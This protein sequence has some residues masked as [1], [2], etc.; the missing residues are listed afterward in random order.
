M[1]YHTRHWQFCHDAGVAT[2]W[3][4]AGIIVSFAARQLLMGGLL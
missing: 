3:F 4:A 1:T 2:V